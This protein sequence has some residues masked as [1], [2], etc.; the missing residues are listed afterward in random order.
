MAI[1]RE[2]PKVSQTLLGAQ[3]T[4]AST[5]DM[6]VSAGNDLTVHGA[7]IAAGGSA[8]VSAGH[9]MTVDAVQSVTSQSLMQNSNRHWEATGVTDETSAITAGGSL[10]MQSGND[11]RFAGAQVTA[12]G[13]LAAVAGGNLTA[14]TVTNTAKYDNV[15]TD[16]RTRQEVDHAWDEQAVGTSF[17]AGGNATLAASVPMRRRAT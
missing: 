13:D 2:I 1:I 12:V 11:M 8:S 16:S 6:I 3:G 15:A 7:A 14:T 17:T 9:D 4:I 5:G 10:A